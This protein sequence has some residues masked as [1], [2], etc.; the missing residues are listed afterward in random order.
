MPVAL[1][2]TIAALAAATYVESL[3]TWV[4]FGTQNPAL[5]T[6]PANSHV[7][8]VQVYVQAAFNSDGT[9]LLTVGYDGTV[10]A[11]VTSLD[12]STTGLK[13][14]TLG[15]GMGY[16]ATSRAVEVYYTAGGSAPTTGSAIVVLRF[17][18]A[19]AA[20]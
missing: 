2:G 1:P 15:S 20:P 13:S 7:L 5:G 9:D 18:R 16:N 3:T 14:P 11:F 19:A 17:V 6:L 8:D 4:S 10:S 12:V